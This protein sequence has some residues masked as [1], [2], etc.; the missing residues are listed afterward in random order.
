MKRFVVGE[1]RDQSTL[2][3]TLLDDFIAE[4][5]PVRAIE[6]FVDGLDLN[7]MGFKG[8]DPHATGRPAYHLFIRF[9]ALHLWLFQSYLIK[10]PIRARDPA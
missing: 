8:G 4:N 2:F 10:S 3:P 6:A 5:N 9:E 1:A 7:D